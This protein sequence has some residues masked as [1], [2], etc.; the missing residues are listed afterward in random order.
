MY[1]YAINMNVLKYTAT[2]FS[3]ISS[4]IF[5]FHTAYL[6]I[7]SIHMNNTRVDAE[8][9]KKGAP[10]VDHHGWP[11]KKKL[12]FRWSKKAKKTLETISFGQNISISNF[13]FS[14]SLSIKSYQFFKI[15]NCVDKKIEKNTHI[16][17]NEK[18]KTEKSWTL[19]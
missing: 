6:N 4:S 9:L 12:G 10:Y 8:I 19:F 5:K 11:A 16:L 2:N 14:P 1:L 15:Y 18:W 17:V 3:S 7:L 13:K